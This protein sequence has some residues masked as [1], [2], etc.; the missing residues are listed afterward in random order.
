MAQRG[1]AASAGTPPPPSSHA[2]RAHPS[3]APAP[4]RP[5]RGGLELALRPT[6]PRGG[7]AGAARAAWRSDL[8]PPSSSPLLPPLPGRRP[9]RS[10]RRSSPELCPPEHRPPH[11]S[12]SR[13]RSSP[14][15]AAARTSPSPSPSPHGRLLL[16]SGRAPRAG[17]GRPSLPRPP[18]AG[19]LSPG[20]ACATRQGCSARCGRAR[21]WSSWP[22]M[23]AAARREAG[24]V[25]TNG[26]KGRCHIA[27]TA[28]EI[29]FGRPSATIPC[30]FTIPTA[31]VFTPNT[32]WKMRRVSF[33]GPGAEPVVFR[34][35]RTR[36]LKRIFHSG[37]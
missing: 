29:Q 36:T 23:T 35:R 13:R 3:A 11:L 33:R 5:W 8:A 18:A 30:S 15:S 22:P 17:G 20:R 1:G 14:A 12:L 10:P 19:L 4:S 16:I 24:V 34:T 27:R 6:P 9:W 31:G 28:L 32:Y 7:A 2:G 21:P 26:G 37:H 25:G